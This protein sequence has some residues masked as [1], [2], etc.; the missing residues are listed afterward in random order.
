MNFIFWLIEF[1]VSTSHEIDMFYFLK[2]PVPIIF[3]F[4]NLI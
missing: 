2:R 1:I 3:H 4:N